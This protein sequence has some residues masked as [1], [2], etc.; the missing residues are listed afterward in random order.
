[1]IRLIASDL[2]GTLLD[3]NGML[4]EETFSTIEKLTSMGIVFAA[5]SGRQYGNLLRLFGPVAKHMAFV[6]ENGSFNVVDGHEAGVI[7]IDDISAREAISDLEALNMNLLVSS[8]QC[9]YMLDCNRRFTDDI[10]YRLRNTVTIIHSWDEITEPITKVSGQIDCGVE[11]FAPALV[12][13]WGN[14]LTATISGKEWFDITAA[15]KGMGILSL[16][17]HMV[18]KP[19]EVMAFGDNYNDVTMLNSVGYPF[20]M[21]HASLAL[22][23]PGIRLCKKV[24]PTIQTL[25]DFD[26]DPVRAF[27]C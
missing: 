9:C 22:R 19:E 1:M 23:K 24:L 26:G 17:K 8:K 6:T 5:A 21:E 12:E 20:L 2:D 10:I 4:P 18:L 14:H 13:K 11:Q 16:M 25:I 27:E 3:E 15:H 7:A